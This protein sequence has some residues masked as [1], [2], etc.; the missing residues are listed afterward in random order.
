VPSRQLAVIT[1]GLAVL[2]VG[3]LIVRDG[4]V[5]AWEESIFRAINDLPPLLN[6]VL[7]PV[8]QLGGLIAGPVLAIVCLILRRYRLAIAV[9]LATIA[10][11]VSERL[12]K[13]VVSRQRPATSIGPDITTRGDVHVVG[14]SFV[15]GHAVLVAA[16]AGVVAPYLPSRWRPVPWVLVALVMVGRVYVGAHNPLDVVC[17]AALG[18]A[19][20]AAIN[21][22]LGV[23]SAR[24]RSTPTH[25]AA[26]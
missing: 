4:S 7:W 3:A 20:A 10:K 15:S 6:P 11:L 1:V 18:V 23:P 26:T 24:P 16:L 25:A 22:A 9:L 21:L 8:Q 17:G 2:A 19:L 12:V 13:A 14:E 5:P